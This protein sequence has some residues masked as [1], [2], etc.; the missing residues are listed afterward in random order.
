MNTPAEKFSLTWEDFPKNA[1]ETFCHLLEEQDFCD[2]TL[3]C[4]D[5]QQ[6]LCHKVILSAS[7]PVIRNML[8]SSIHSHPLL[9]FWGVKARD[10][11]RLVDF[12]YR[13]QVQLYQSDL[14]DF[15]NLAELL[16]VK[17]VTWGKTRQESGINPE[18]EESREYFIRASKEKY[19]SQVTGDEPEIP[20]SKYQ[21]IYE[22]KTPNSE[23]Q[24]KEEI[25]KSFNIH[26]V[27]SSPPSPLSLDTYD[28][29]PPN[30]L[31]DSP[32]G[33][34]DAQ[35]LVRKTYTN[36]SGVNPS[37]RRTYR[38]KCTIQWRDS[39]TQLR[40][41]HGDKVELW[42]QQVSETEAKCAW[43]QSTM[44]FDSKGV[45]ALFLHAKRQKHKENHDV[46][47]FNGENKAISE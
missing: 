29:S 26:D 5:N 6:I 30:A 36:S 24:L 31:L 34:T 25:S 39:W 8:R 47:N 9:Y 10:L 38:E 32:A 12:I 28:T 43:C 33:L 13:G 4:E 45:G 41:S 42:A 3:V 40:D 2:V 19:C 21:P 18:S 22:N 1:G 11:A 15:L 44:K 14:P 27:P 20:E 16:K 23:Q 35:P 46:L 7:S 37:A 17:G